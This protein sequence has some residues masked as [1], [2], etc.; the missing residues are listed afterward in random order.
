MP[1]LK[2]MVRGSLRKDNTYSCVIRITHRRKSSFIFT[3]IY[4]SAHEVTKSGK[5]KSKLAS[6]SKTGRYIR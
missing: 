3:G 4:V 1:T 6:C 5:I 2:Y